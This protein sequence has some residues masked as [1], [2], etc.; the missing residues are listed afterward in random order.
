MKKFYILLVALIAFN[1]LSGQGW[2][3]LNP[4]PTGN[5]LR[6]LSFTGENTWYAVGEKGTIVK[7]TNGGADWQGQPSGTTIDLNSLCFLDAN[8][9]LAV[10]WY[11]TIL[12][13]TNGGIS[14][15]GVDKIVSTSHTLKIFPNPSLNVI[16]VESSREWAPGQ[17]SVMSMNGEVM[18][19]RQTNGSQTHL[20]IGNLPC[21]IYFVRLT[22]SRSA[23]VGKFV[24]L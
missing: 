21:G 9:G 22:T 11:G 18:I 24:K 7:T 12:M 15:G 10:G 5:D 17:L 23:E 6:S 4:S 2:Q 8:K 1:S 14:V 20:D 16:T 13:T 19:S 3:W